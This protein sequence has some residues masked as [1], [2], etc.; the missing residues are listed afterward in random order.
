MRKGDEMDVILVY[1]EPLIVIVLFIG[2]IVLWKRKRLQDIR[3]T[4]VDPQVLSRAKTPVQV[5][6]AR[7]LLFMTAMVVAIIGLHTFAP[8][9]WPPLVRVT[10]LDSLSVDMIGGLVGVFGLSICALAQT[11]MG[12]SWRVGIDTEHPTDLI[13]IGIYKYVRN[14]TYLGLH[15]VNL[16]LW[17]IWPTTMVA[18]YAVLFFI[19]MDIQVRA[20]EEHLYKTHGEVYQTYAATSRRYLPWIY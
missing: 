11:T 9:T 10:A 1:L 3:L 7:L 8:K 15:L 18:F 14:P 12:S 19:V 2:Y 4:G 13:T 17:F 20:E 16:G 5:Y 6:F